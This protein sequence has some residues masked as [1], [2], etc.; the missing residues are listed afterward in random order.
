MPVGWNIF[1]L[2]GIWTTP[3]P[4]DNKKI[5][6]FSSIQ[7]K[8]RCSAGITV[9]EIRNNLNTFPLTGKKGLYK[10]CLFTSNSIHLHSN[11]GK[12]VCGAVLLF[13]TPFCSLPL[14]FKP[15]APQGYVCFFTDQC[16]KNWLLSSGNQH[17]SMQAVK[18]ASSFVC[19]LN[20]QQIDFMLFLLEKMMVEQHTAYVFKSEL[21]NNY[22][23]L[24]L[25]EILKMKGFVSL[26]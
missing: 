15:A 25:C 4:M 11:E 20:P 17:L 21:L 9:Y 22:L 3:P 2:S 24:L 16:L 18:L 26:N 8:N 13:A 23:F 5:L 7:K 19:C 1:A 6:P 10:I 14:A 12:D